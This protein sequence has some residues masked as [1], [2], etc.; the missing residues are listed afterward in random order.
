LLTVN[1][2]NFVSASVAQ[3]NGSP[4]AT[5]FVSST[6]LTAAVPA[7]SRLNANGNLIAVNTP[8][9]AGGLSDPVSV[10]IGPTISAGGIQ[11]AAASVTPAVLT[12]GTFAAIYGVQLAAQPAQAVAAPFP[13]TLGGVN[14]T[15]NAMQAP[16]YYVSPTQINFVVPWETSGTQATIVVQVNG[17]T[18]NSM[19]VAIA[20]G[21]PQIF[22]VNQQGTGQADALIAGTAFLAAPVGAFPGSQPVQRGG[23][24]SIYATGLGAV[25]NQPADGTAPS[26]LS[27]TV[28]MPSVAI[29]STRTDEFFEAVY[30]QFSGLAPGFVGLYQVNVQIPQNAATGDAVPLV[31]FSSRSAGGA[32]GVPSNTVTIAIQ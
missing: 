21:A 12:P 9:N 15:V 17:L 29:G 6:Q 1:G 23:Y 28:L 27:P 13:V 3:M 19:N 2:V 4:L 18:S 8:G 31:L 30:P 24:I 25:Q 20:P 32:A 16:L 11:N 7:G 26:G 10:V 14:V 22:T 5:A